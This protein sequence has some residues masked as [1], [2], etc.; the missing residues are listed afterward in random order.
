MTSLLL[1]HTNPVPDSVFIFQVLYVED[2]SVHVFTAPS[3]MLSFPR[4]FCERSDVSNDNYTTVTA[5]CGE[6]ATIKVRS[7]RRPPHPR[8]CMSGTLSG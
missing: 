5:D 8:I 2:R 3:C 7:V 6:E 1:S 4:Y